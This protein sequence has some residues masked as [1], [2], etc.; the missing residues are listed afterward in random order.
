MA[1]MTLKLKKKE[2]GLALALPL[3]NRI[4][5][6]AI[7]ALYAGTMAWGFQAPIVF[8]ILGLIAFLGTGYR[9]TWHF[10][11]QKKQ[12]R[13]G[14]GLYFFWKR[15]SWDYSEVDH[16]NLISFVR[17]KKGFVDPLMDRK[18]LFH[19]KQSILKIT[20]QGREQVLEAAT[21]RRTLVLMEYGEELAQEM[22]CPFLI[23]QE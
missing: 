19:T 16:I 6:G 5:F 20:H 21:N 15:E 22:D 14:I 8:H 18:G 12:V 23:N 4:V 10:D 13:Y 17:G 9:E 11:H 7:L 1:F 3:Y 2:G